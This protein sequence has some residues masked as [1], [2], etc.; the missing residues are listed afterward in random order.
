MLHHSKDKVKPPRNLRSA[1][2]SLV[3]NKISTPLSFPTTFHSSITAPKKIIK[4]LYD[5]Q[6]Q[7]PHELSFKQGDFFHV[8]ARENDDQWFEACNPATNLKGIVPVSYFQVLDKSERN[9]TVAQP[10]QPQK[11][12]SGFIDHESP[13]ANEAVNI[14][15]G[16]KKMQPL[17]GVVLYDFQ[18]ERSDELDAKAGEP[19]IVI[20][21]SNQ[22][23]FVAKPIGRLG[24]PGLIPVSFVEVRDAVT[25]KP[26]TNVA[27]MMHNTSTPIPRVEEW[28]KMTQGYE[29][30]SISLGSIEKQQML[31]SGFSESPSS[32]ISSATSDRLVR[33][34]QNG[35][36]NH[37]HHAGH[38]NNNNATTTDA[39]AILDSYGMQHLAQ[40]ST[41]DPATDRLSSSYAN[42]P[43]PR[44]SRSTRTDRPMVEAANIDSYILE[45]DQYWFIVYARLT[46]GRHRVLYRLYEDF[47]DFQISLLSEYPLE[48]GKADRERILPY[49]PGPLT[50]VDEEITAERQR[51]LDKYCR[52]LLSLPRYLAESPIVQSQLFGIHEGD[53][54]TDCDPRT[55]TN[56]PVEG[57]ETTTTTPVPVAMASTSPAMTPTTTHSG[58]GVSATSASAGAGAG[59]SATKSTV[60]LKIVHKD[61]IFAIKVP[62]DITLDQLCAK[63]HDR[64]GFD[65]SLRYKDE[66]TGDSLPLE[67]ELDMEEAFAS[68]IKLGKLTVYA[69]RI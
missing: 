69:Q 40:A 6:A 16:A 65:V 31:R 23:W 37:H 66:A 8:T 45:G 3:K 58:M 28:K 52:E 36:D 27:D 61:D 44:E 53:I 17:Y 39:D 38:N 59:T 63:V 30:S 13:L 15:P 14:Q 67:D 26:I 48:A 18:A 2:R 35:Y 32:S 68:A 4:A 57:E 62:T 34:Q 55:G 9:L 56:Q 1:R 64:L 12:D 51:D 11:A 5:Y 19:I 50:D 41:L 46:N 60:K 54:E 47:Y 20:A 33:S 42:G 49:M 7:G 22:E 21:Q 10:Q 24:G 43:S 25:G 29:A